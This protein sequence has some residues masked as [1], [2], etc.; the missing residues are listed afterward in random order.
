[1]SS[2]IRVTIVFD[3]KKTDRYK[4][5]YCSADVLTPADSRRMRRAL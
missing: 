5:D 3:N 4:K 1:M 2:G